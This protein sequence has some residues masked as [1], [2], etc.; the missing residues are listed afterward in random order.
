MQPLLHPFH[1][2]L[3]LFSLFQ[4][5]EQ[6]IWQRVVLQTPSFLAFKYCGVEHMISK[7]PFINL[8]KVINSIIEND[9]KV[10]QS[11]NEAIVFIILSKTHAKIIKMIHLDRM[12]HLNKVLVLNIV[13][14]I[15][16]RQRCFQSVIPN[17]LILEG[18]GV[19]DVWILYKP[20]SIK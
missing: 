2:A 9:G 18:L 19:K 3:Q 17:Q 15:I 12:Q 16:A 20:F 1:L 5:F 8:L 6:L 13:A 4:L 7:V 10:L 14:S 11:A